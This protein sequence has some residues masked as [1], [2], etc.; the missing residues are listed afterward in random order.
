MSMT[1]P[2]HRKPT[3][4]AG[5][6]QIET[7][8]SLVYEPAH[9]VARYARPIQRYL[10]A[11]I[12]NEHDA[13]EVAQDFLLWVSQHGLPRASQDRG[14][15]RDYLKKIV[16][17]VALNF[18]NRQQPPRH[19]DHGLLT[20]PA[21]DAAQHGPDQE[22]VA[23][24][25]HCL[26]QRAWRR[27]ER[28]QQRSPDNLF[29]T[30]LRLCARHPGEDSKSLAERASRLSGKPLRPDAFRKQVS[31]A[32]LKFAEYL[33]QEIAETLD[34]PT[35]ADVEEEL[36]DLGLMVYVHDFLP[37]HRRSQSH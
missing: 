20:V 7:D 27:L 15:F 4:D 31:R 6:D 25:R 29:H 10:C 11:L 19:S 37:L 35:P 34:R 26:L 12:K 28:H 3:A 36:V 23:Q 1:H 18:I 2:A 21:A 22:W 16:R 33:V 8:W 24:W 9:L 32:R 30:V 13:E 5:L 17:N 14:R